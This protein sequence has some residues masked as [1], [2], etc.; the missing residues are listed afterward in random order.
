MRKIR[1]LPETREKR[2]KKRKKK[3]ITV[4]GVTAGSTCM[5][6]LYN[7]RSA[8]VFSRAGEGGTRGIP[9]VRKP[10]EGRAWTGFM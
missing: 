6:R 9:L 3:E 4:K 1:L 5:P 8:G 2:K 10:S 7:R